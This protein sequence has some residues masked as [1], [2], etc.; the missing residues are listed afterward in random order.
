MPQLAPITVSDGKVTPVIHTFSPFS[1]DQSIGLAVWK[2]R[3]GVYPVGYPTM[4]AKFSQ[5]S[6]T[7]AKGTRTYKVR[8]SLTLPFTTEIYSPGSTYGVPAV[9]YEAKAIVE[10]HLPEASTKI[11]RKDLRVLLNNAL[12][13]AD[14]QKV[15]DDLEGVW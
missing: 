9:M 13:H 6:A 4:T 5:P 1:M 11:E 3:S 8:V 7:Q 2:D 14:L 15:I 12:A 10:F